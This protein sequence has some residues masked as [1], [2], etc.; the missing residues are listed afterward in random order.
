MNKRIL[1]ILAALALFTTSCKKEN[2]VTTNNE[3][4][5]E[6]QVPDNFSWK[7]VH[8]VNVSVG[9][10]DSRFGNQMFVVSIYL[11]NPASGGNPIAKGTATLTSAFNAKVSLPS[12]TSEIY[13]VKTAPDGSSITTKQ[14]VGTANKIS[15]SLSDVLNAHDFTTL[16]I[17]TTAA[18]TILEP[19]CGRSVNNTNIDIKGANDVV[20]FNS[21]SDVTIDVSANLGGTLKLNAPNKT[22]TIGNNFNHTNL[23]LFIGKDTKVVFTKSFDLKSGEVLQNNGTLQTSHFNNSGIL[24]NNGTATFSGSNF[25]LNSDGQFINNGTCT[26]ET[27][28]PT[29]SNVLVNNGHLTFTGNMTINSSAEVTNNCSLTV[30]ETFRVN[31]SKVWNYSLIVVNGDTYI[32][33]TGVLSLYNGA[34][35]Q[36]SVLS[37][38]DGVVAGLGDV[39]SLFKVVNSVGQNVKNNHGLF[40]GNLQYSGKD[41]IEDNNNKVKHFSDGATKGSDVYIAKDDCNTIGNG[42]APA[43]S[44]PDS[45]KDGVMDEQD[46]YPKDATK[47]FNNYSYNY[48]N[49]GSTIVFEDNWPAKADYDMND[50]VFRYKHLVV[51]NANNVVVRLE[52]EW[53]LLATG[54]DFKNGAGIMFNLPKGKAANFSASNGL[55]PEEGQDSLVVVLFKNSRDEMANWN[56]KPGESLSASR[57]YTFSFDVTNGPTLDSFGTGGY[58]PFIWNGSNGFG[59]GYETH[60]YGQAP[61]KLAD[62]AIF[63]T[64]DDN[65]VPGKYY[66]TADNLP[67]GFEIPVADFQYPIEY[68]DIRTA[69][70][71]FSSWATSGGTKD[72]DWYSKTESG[73]RNED[74]IF[75]K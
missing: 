13:L 30:G 36:T 54:G 51:T 66:T 4:L 63:G 38:M 21:T 69:Y 33:G 73:Y 60:L 28:L 34:M 56:T 70:L 44:K 27:Q 68:K 14:N 74:T 64:K 29:I 12:N 75:K 45:D 46:E 7:M 72:F 47:A 59:R 32:N 17:G 49:G 43:P 58:N 18:N 8:D 22:I 35:V 57:K 40:K 26:V 15:V 25:N 62:P 37:N 53:N 39:R 48:E 24:V 52:G 55:E 3:Q 23:K 61:T 9:I 50:I 65:S 6:L 67:W 10:T 31:S 41:D 1:T 2:T 42:T 71:K 11:N 16:A 19:A 5:S 20:C